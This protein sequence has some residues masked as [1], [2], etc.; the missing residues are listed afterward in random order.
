MTEQSSRVHLT[1]E[2]IKEITDMAELFFPPEDIAINVGIDI[3]EFKI[4]VLS[5]QGE[6]FRAFK[7]GWLKGEIPLRKGI[8]QAAA[9]G[10]NP[11]QVKLLDLK[12]ESESLFDL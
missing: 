2:Q 11:A 10:S 8:A 9:N 1:E 7:T 4:A 5:K 12:K 3:E 6:I